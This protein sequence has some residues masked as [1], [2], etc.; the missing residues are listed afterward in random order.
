MLDGAGPL[1]ATGLLPQRVVTGQ[2]HGNRGAAG[3][4]LR[5]HRLPQRRPQL[6]D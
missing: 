4:C 3:P 2:I 6:H 5:P 1:S